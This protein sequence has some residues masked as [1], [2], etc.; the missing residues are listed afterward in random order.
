MSR[1]LSHVRSW[2]NFYIKGGDPKLRPSSVGRPTVQRFVLFLAL[3]MLSF[4]NDVRAQSSGPQPD[5]YAFCNWYSWPAGSDRRHRFFNTNVFPASWELLQRDRLAKTFIDHT[6]ENDYTEDLRNGARFYECRYFAD[7][8]SAEKLRRTSDV[9]GG[10]EWN[11]IKDFYPFGRTLVKP[12]AKRHSVRARWPNKGGNK[13]GGYTDASIGVDYQFIVCADEIVMAYA[14]D[15]K[16]VE[17]G[18][19]YARS[20]FETVSTA[21]VNIPQPSAITLRGTISFDL[22][23][24]PSNEA[25]RRFRSQK[26]YDEFAGDALGF[27][28]FTG[29]TR[30]IGKV[31]DLIGPKPAKGEVEA[32]LEGLE[33]INLVAGDGPLANAALDSSVSASDADRIARERAEAERLAKE[34][35]EA[36]DLARRW[37]ETERK[38]AELEARDAAARKARADE[39]AKYEREVAAKKAADEKYARDLAAFEAETKRVEAKRAE[40]ERQ[41]EAYRRAIANGAK[42]AK[43]Q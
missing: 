38:R 39:L 37:E 14:I 4:A 8:E 28:C 25:G 32:F 13:R 27:G 36:E 15:P 11:Y 5:G 1:A 42:P 33:F 26:F 16:S 24:D 2:Q 20:D 40:Y 12:T 17:V 6:Q 34:R 31:A 21:G 30:S 19:N 22:A 41:M 35:A 23:S 7:E 9:F 10:D 18:P 43:P 29:Q 3:V